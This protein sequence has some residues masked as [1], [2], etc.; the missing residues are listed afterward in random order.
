MIVHMYVCIHVGGVYMCLYVCM[1]V[2]AHV[3]EECACVRVCAFMCACV[4]VIFTLLV[5]YPSE[6]RFG[7]SCSTACFHDSSSSQ[8][9]KLLLS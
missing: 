6:K 3:W 4:C 8:P 9:M 5:S 7:T 2:S 1:C